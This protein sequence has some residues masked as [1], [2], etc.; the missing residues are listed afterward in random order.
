MPQENWIA[1]ANLL[2]AKGVK[3]EDAA[4]K[5]SMTEQGF[6][7]SVKIKTFN[8]FRQAQLALQTGISLEEIRRI[9]DSDTHTLMNEPGL[10]FVPV[11]RINKSTDPHDMLRRLFA[12][13]YIIDEL[14]ERERLSRQQKDANDVAGFAP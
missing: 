14:V 10:G 9:V 8:H 7:K 12:N 3:I 4:K 5:I 13:R 11:E 2:K 1:L 6:R